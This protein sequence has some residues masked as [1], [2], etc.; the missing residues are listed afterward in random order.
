MRI[1]MMCHASFGGSARIGIELAMALAGRGHRVHLFTRTT[2][3]GC[4]DR[5]NSVVLHTLLPD[6]TDTL[7]PPQPCIR[8]GRNTICGNTPRMC[9]A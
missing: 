7:P 8:T 3:L 2:P 1:G 9:C 4:W 6:A 5:S